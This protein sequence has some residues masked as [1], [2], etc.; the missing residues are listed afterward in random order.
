MDSPPPAPG[1]KIV[2]VGNPGVGKTAL[3]ERFQGHDIAGAH[4]STLGHKFAR[5]TARAPCGTLVS[6]ALWDTAGQE[7]F[8]GIVPLYFK[9]CDFIL[10]VYDVAD[11]ASFTSLPEWIQLAHDSAPSTT[12]L[13]VIANK[14]DQEIQRLTPEQGEAFATQVLAL[15]FFQTSALTKQGIPDVLQEIATAA[16]AGNM[17]EKRSRPAAASKVEGSKCC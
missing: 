4:I 6:L 9:D 11:G 3:F 5:V 7:Q 15:A 2:M 17:L 8:R 1:A 12:K 16:V 13:I 14:I 10:L